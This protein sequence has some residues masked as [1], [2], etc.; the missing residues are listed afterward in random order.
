MNQEV[1]LVVG[2][3]SKSARRA[4]AGRLERPSSAGT[5]DFQ[6]GIEIALAGGLYFFV[7]GLGLLFGQPQAPLV[8]PPAGIAVAAPLIFG[9]R[10]WPG[11]FLGAWFLGLTTGNDPLTISAVAVG[12]T[13]EGLVAAWLINRYAG[14]ARFYKR[15]LDIVRFV[16]LA[17]VLTPLLSPPFGLANISWRSLVFWTHDSSTLAVWWLGELASALVLTPLLV[18][19]AANWRVRWGRARTA[20]FAVLLLLLTA[21]SAAVFTNLAPAWAQSYLLPYLCLPFPLWAA[22]RFGPGATMIA[23]CA[24][25]LVA[26]WGTH[27]GFGLFAWTVPDKA[28][29]AYEGFTAFNSFMGLIVA[30]VVQQREEAQRALQRANDGLDLEVHQ[31]TKDLR[32]EIDVRKQTEASL[33]KARDELEQR[34]Q[35]R[36]AELTQVNQ[37]LKNENGQRRRAEEALSRVLQ[38]LIDAQETERCRISRELHDEMGQNLNALKLGLNAARDDGLRLGLALP[39]LPQLEMLTAR[40]LQNV[41]RLAWELRPP[42]LDD[43]GLAPA[44]QRYTEQWSAQSGIA[45]DFHDLAPQS[46]RLPAPIETALYRVTQEALTNVV[47]HAKARR[48]SVLLDRQS[49]CVSLIVEDDGQGFTGGEILESPTPNG[50]MGLVGIRERVASAGGNL[51]IESTLGAGTGRW[52]R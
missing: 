14:G 25:A 44:L 32:A 48:V 3:S 17:G 42:A 12:N 6:R 28:L 5:W 50:K 52:T 21:V 24:Q 45:V 36:T 46:Q 10:I 35:D 38:R 23:T 51:Q 7:G 34:V 49:E 16:F 41:H 13:L 20:E 18:L 33:A 37:R 22:L 2:D 39:S 19:W 15:P 29:M 4:E 9:F 26:L 43:L 11:V 47:K 27:R 31:C 1:R 40:L 8:F 30:A